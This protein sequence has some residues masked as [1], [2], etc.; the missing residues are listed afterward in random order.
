MQTLF[1]S[2]VK[3]KI[4]SFD[5][6]KFEVNEKSS[7]PKLCLDF[8]FYQKLFVMIFMSCSFLIFPESPRDSEVVCRKYHSREACNIW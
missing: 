3:L 6:S 4:A 7:N 8:K 5:S 1:D 2:R